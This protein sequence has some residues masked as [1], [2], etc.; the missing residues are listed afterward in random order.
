M[1]MTR[2]LVFVIKWIALI[3]VTTVVCAFFWFFTTLWLGGIFF[4][5]GIKDHP[6]FLPQGYELMSN[7]LGLVVFIFW[8]GF[9]LFAGKRIRFVQ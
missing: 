7:A 8:L 1:T 6:D 2:F 5:V 9:L 4:D 3:A